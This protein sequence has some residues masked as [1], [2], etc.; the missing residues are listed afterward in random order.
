MGKIVE[1]IDQYCYEN[2][3]DERRTHLG[4]SI[5]GDECGRK[6]WLEFRWAL[7][8]KN[9]P[10]M[11]RLLE[12]GKKEEKVFIHFLEKIGVKVEQ[13]DPAT[14]KQWRFT[15]YKGQFCGSSDGKGSG[16]IFDHSYLLEFKT[17][18]DKSFKD[19]INN[20]VRNSK[21]EHYVQ[22]T[23]Y[24]GEMDLTKCLYLAVNKNHDDLYDEIIDFNPE[25]YKK[26]KTR[27]IQ[28]IDAAEPPPRI[29]NNPTWYQCKMCDYHRLCHGRALPDLN[30]RTC[31]HS[32]PVENGRWQCE[33]YAGN[34]LI[35]E[36]VMGQG[37]PNYHQHPME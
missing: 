21:P 1:L 10:W 9:E 22:V 11:V 27:A 18:S 26:Y 33:F 17:H 3:E 13:I 12:R 20:G 28:L 8:L 2:Q 30:C 35:P 6:I 23:M 25:M 34:P 29:S 4:P 16:V 19:L 36:N 7:K 5:L 32:T 31:A 24:M 37:C 15:G 14:G